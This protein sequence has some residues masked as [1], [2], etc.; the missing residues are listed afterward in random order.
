MLKLMRPAYVLALGLSLGAVGLGLMTYAVNT[1]SLILVIGGAVLLS[2]GTAPGT[3]I[4]ADLIVGAAPQD[5]SG[6]ASALNETTSEFGGALGI[7]LFGSLATLVYRQRLSQFGPGDTPAAAMEVALRG[8]G[9]ATG[10]QLGSEG[11][12]FQSIVQGAYVH[13]ISVAFVTAAGILLLAALIS[14]VK[15]RD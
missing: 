5:R 13:A 6:A 7:A 10:L 2:V 14:I 12:R 9:A 8:I 15:F 3:A 11:G 4:I 1:A